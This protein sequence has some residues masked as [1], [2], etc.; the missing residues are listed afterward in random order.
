MGDSVKALLAQPTALSS[1]ASAAHL[2]EA[3]AMRQRIAAGHILGLPLSE[4]M[5]SHPTSSDS[6][7]VPS[8]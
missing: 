3:A 7:R 6:R 1:D 4:D 2:I 5:S 8:C